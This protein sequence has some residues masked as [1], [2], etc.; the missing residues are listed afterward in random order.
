MGGGGAH[1]GSPW[2]LMGSLPPMHAR[3]T[4]E[5]RI[6]RGENRAGF[7]EARPSS[8]PQL[9]PRKKEHREALED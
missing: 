5:R 1:S 3:A 8:W 6:T 9:R 4:G 2:A 7:S